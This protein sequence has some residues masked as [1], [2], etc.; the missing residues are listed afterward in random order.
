M[1]IASVLI[2]VCVAGCLTPPIPVGA[3]KSPREAQRQ[4]AA[5]LT[6][7]ELATPASYHGD[8]RVA[9]VRVYADAEYRAQNI[10]WEQAF[11]DALANANAT[12]G[13]ALGVR[14][15]AEYKSW[16][17][18]AP[19]A[20]LETT[21][22]E[23]AK[24]DDGDGVLSVIA[25][26]SSRGLTEAT[27]DHLGVAALGGHHIVLRGYADVEERAVLERSFR[28]LS[29][30]ERERVYASRRRHKTTAVLLHELGHNLGV[31]HEVDP[32][33]LMN[34]IYSDHSTAFSEHSLEVMRAML[35]RR[36]GPGG[37]RD[38]GP[39][40]AHELPGAPRGAH[41]VLH[42]A[43]AANGDLELDGDPIAAGPLDYAL[44]AAVAKDK[45]TELVV[46]TAK[47]GPRDVTIRVVDRAKA[48]G[49]QR[50]SI[51]LGAAA[52]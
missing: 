17:Y 24:L 23:L 4:R 40:I 25:L 18:H 48:A 13:A 2:A 50:I 42:V 16:D 28:W 3:G 27:F 33:T 20:T 37:H 29:V 26:T 11:G 31:P 15:E 12:L 44:A 22:G 1:R 7:P 6:A 30:A 14:L 5:E 9:K 51:E 49:V 10:H 38:A 35:D 46:T 52:P 39:A 43:I 34:A 21:L 41:V 8:L 36:L 32:E 45:D 47:H 19:G